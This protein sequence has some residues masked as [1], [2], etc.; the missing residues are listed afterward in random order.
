MGGAAGLVSAED[1]LA[2]ARMLLRGG[3]PV[4]VVTHVGPVPHPRYQS[5]LRGVLTMMQPPGVGIMRKL[6]SSS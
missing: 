6:F 2:F 5:R 4:L 3:D 1:L